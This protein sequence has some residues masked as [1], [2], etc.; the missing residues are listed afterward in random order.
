[1]GSSPNLDSAWRAAALSVDAGRVLFGHL[2]RR[3]NFGTAHLH[4]HLTKLP[5][6]PPGA[7][8]RPPAI[9]VDIERV[10]HCHPTAD[11][12]TFAHDHAARHAMIDDEFSGAKA[13]S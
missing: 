4:R 8:Q 2:D 11:G 1:M 5:K 7:S 3:Q 6:N 9:K 12:E 13:Q 10:P